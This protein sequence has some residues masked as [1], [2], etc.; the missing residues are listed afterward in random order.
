MWVNRINAPGMSRSFLAIAQF[1]FLLYQLAVL[2]DLE[3]FLKRETVE[4]AGRNHFKFYSVAQS[5]SL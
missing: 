1:A 5:L 4:R 3:I 2:F